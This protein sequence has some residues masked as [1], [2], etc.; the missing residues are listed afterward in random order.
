MTQAEL[1][2]MNKLILLERQRQLLS[3]ITKSNNEN[4]DSARRVQKIM[5]SPQVTKLLNSISIEERSRANID[6]V[7]SDTAV[8]IAPD[9]N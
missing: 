9:E 1:P 3:S 6:Q 5:K 2:N 8:A 4:Q 7:L